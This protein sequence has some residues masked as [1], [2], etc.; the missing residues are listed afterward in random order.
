MGEHILWAMASIRVAFAMLLVGAQPT[1]AQEPTKPSTSP[2]AATTDRRVD[3]I[4]TREAVRDSLLAQRPAFSNLMVRYRYHS[5]LLGTAENARRYFGVKYPTDQQEIYAIK[6]KKR[7]WQYQRTASL[8]DRHTAITPLVRDQGDHTLTTDANFAVAFNGTQLTRRDPG[9]HTFSII[10]LTSVKIEGHY[11]KSRYLDML[12]QRPP[13]VLVAAA[14]KVPSLLDVLETGECSIRPKLENVD[15]ALCAVVDWHS[16]LHKAAWCDPQL[17]Y[18][19]RQRATYEGDSELITWRFIMSD[20]IEVRP[21]IWLPRKASEIRS[22][23]SKAPEEL[24]GV[25]LFA[26]D[27]EVES[28]RLDDIPDELFD[29]KFTAGAIVSDFSK[30]ADDPAT[31]QRVAKSFRA[32]VDGKVVEVPVQRRVDTDE[33]RHDR[34]RFGFWLILL[35]VIAVAIVGAGGWHRSRRSGST[36]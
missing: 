27:C 14:S 13:D 29:L 24:Q 28:I 32:T 2:T 5:R 20:F 8:D 22:P 33:L 30:G 21:G 23:D 3:L 36:S 11:F 12:G 34:S 1:L 16:P 6:G 17:G 9:G 7:Y 35:Q 15:G 26:Y 4:P 25:P 31:G 19:V 10:D 18:A